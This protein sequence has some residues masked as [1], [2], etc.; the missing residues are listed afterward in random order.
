MA[1]EA[2]GFIL[3]PYKTRQLLTVVRE[4]P[5]NDPAG[6]IDAENEPRTVV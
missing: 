2:K 6:P 3:K 5:D 4:I 1:L